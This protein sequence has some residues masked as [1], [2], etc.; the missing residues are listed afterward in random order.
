MVVT[1]V[2]PLP[3]EIEEFVGAYFEVFPPEV[4]A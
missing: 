1:A 4:K 3:V 2:D